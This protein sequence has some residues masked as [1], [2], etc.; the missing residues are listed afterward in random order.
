MADTERRKKQ[1][2]ARMQKSLY[3]RAAE[4]LRKA[5]D[6]AEK[7]DATWTRVHSEAGLNLIRAAETL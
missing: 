4:E 6:Y 2:D 1:R 5:A 7:K 3:L